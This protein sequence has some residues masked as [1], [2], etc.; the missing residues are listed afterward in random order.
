MRSGLRKLEGALTEQGH[1]IC[2]ETVR[3]LLYKHD[4]RPHSNRKRLTPQADPQ[5]DRQF[6]YIQAQREAFKAL[7]WPIISVDTKHKELIG[8]YYNA[9]RVWTRQATDVYMTDFPS[10]AV[11]KAVPYGIYDLLNN[12][13]YVAVGQSADTSAFAVDAIVWWWQHFG[14]QHFPQAP[15]LLILADSGGSNNY[16]YPIGMWMILVTKPLV[17]QH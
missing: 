6:R 9:G 8:P 5:R 13:G 4:I 16:R 7:G 10:D 2:H 11:G 3:R 1:A 17:L 14:C 12:L 15:E